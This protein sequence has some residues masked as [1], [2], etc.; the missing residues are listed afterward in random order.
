MHEKWLKGYPFGVVGAIVG[1]A[2]GYFYRPSAFM[3]GQ[4]PFQHVISRGKTLKGIDQ[5]LL[6]VA[7]T[8][9]HYLIGGALIGAVMGLVINGILDHK[10]RRG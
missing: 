6:P 4:L 8:S 7:E 3:V 9:F 2:I 1:G 5:I 10:A